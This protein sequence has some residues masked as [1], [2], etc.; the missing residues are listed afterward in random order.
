MRA[1][2]SVARICTLAALAS[3]AGLVPAWGAERCTN[4]E[5]FDDSH[6]LPEIYRQ[7]GFRFDF[8]DQGASVLE[9]TAIFWAHQKA[10]VKTPFAGKEVSLEIVARTAEQ[11]R[12]K[13]VNAEGKVVAVFNDMPPYP[14]PLTIA[15]QAPAADI[16]KLKLTGGGNES[17]IAKDRK[18]VV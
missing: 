1:G 13:A 16:V 8:G 3:A 6:Q 12:V 18:S 4:F 7:D 15:L 10:S 2:F 11:I 17:G 5:R 9:H 14:H